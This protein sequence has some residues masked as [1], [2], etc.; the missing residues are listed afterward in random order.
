[1]WG[2]RGGRVAEGW[3]SQAGVGWGERQL[4]LGEVEEEVRVLKAALDALQ[5]T[6]AAERSRTVTATVACLLRCPRPPSA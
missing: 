2:G 4:R 3:E 5:R 1:M 6:F